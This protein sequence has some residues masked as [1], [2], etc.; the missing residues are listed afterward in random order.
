MWIAVSECDPYY[1]L[2]R[3]QLSVNIIPSVPALKKIEKNVNTIKLQ[4]LN[5][6][7]VCCGQNKTWQEINNHFFSRSIFNSMFTIEGQDVYES[8]EW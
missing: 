1:A 2:F 6:F 7:L 3:E 5:I 8:F 4:P